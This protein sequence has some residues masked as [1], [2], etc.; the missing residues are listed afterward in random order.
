ML[1]VPDRLILVVSAFLYVDVTWLLD[2]KDVLKLVL[3]SVVDG[4]MG[5]L[6]DVGVVYIIVD[7][8]GDVC[9]VELVFIILIVL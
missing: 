7:F 8:A 5:E 4:L 2:L 3:T 6:V 1:G 9:S